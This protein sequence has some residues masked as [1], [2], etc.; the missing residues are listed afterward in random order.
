MTLPWKIEHVNWHCCGVWSGSGIKMKSLMRVRIGLNTMPI[1]NKTKI[2]T[3]SY[4]VYVCWRD[5]K[6]KKLRNRGGG[7]KK[8]CQECRKSLKS[9]PLIS[10]PAPLVCKNMYF[11]QER[12]KFWLVN[13]RAISANSR[14]E[15]STWR[16]SCRAVAHSQ[17]GRKCWEIFW[18]YVPAAWAS[19]TELSPS[20]PCCRRQQRHP[21]RGGH[22]CNYYPDLGSCRPASLPSTSCHFF[23]A[24]RLEMKS[25]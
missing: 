13:L 14:R 24:I 5:R 4:V 12:G 20:S 7:D 23:K 6:W 10:V 21:H 16:V 9:F 19:G 15:K 3:E 17:T 8:K 25:R 2:L 18:Q 1:H 22:C 11:I